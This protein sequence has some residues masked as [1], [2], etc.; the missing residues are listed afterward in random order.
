MGDKTRGLYD[1]FTVI[2]NDFS[3]GPGGKHYNCE[4]LVLDL[5]HD[6]F[7][8]PAARAYAE[9]CRAEYPLLAEDLD[10]KLRALAILDEGGDHA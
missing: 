3:D 5:T 2:R 8:I 9:A 7:A 10:K 1:K 6:Q 4:Y